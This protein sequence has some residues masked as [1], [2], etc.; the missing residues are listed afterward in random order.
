MKD[1]FGTCNLD[2]FDPIKW[3]I[4]LFMILLSG[5]NCI[6]LPGY[7]YHLVNVTGF[8]VCFDNVKWVI[9]FNLKALLKPWKIIKNY[10]LVTYLPSLHLFWFVKQK[11]SKYSFSFN[12][13][14]RGELLCL[15]FASQ[16]TYFHFLCFPFNI[17]FDI[18]YGTIGQ[19]GQ[20][21][22]LFSQNFL[23]H[24]KINFVKKNILD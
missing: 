15:R 8:S 24:L 11:Y 5:A 9:L 1:K 14:K 6:Y 17:S 22:F 18:A 10:N 19:Q 4:T 23:N 20:F 13:L 16:L 21:L 12:L 2:E 7:C 3:L